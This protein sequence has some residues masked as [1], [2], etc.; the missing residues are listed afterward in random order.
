MCVVTQ[1]TCPEQGRQVFLFN[2]DW[3]ASA[4]FH[5]QKPQPEVIVTST[6]PDGVRE[7]LILAV[8]AAT[9]A[10]SVNLEQIR[11]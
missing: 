8:R 7:T 11:L 3:T 2:G 10:L 5:I 4:D 9:A 6:V 1:R